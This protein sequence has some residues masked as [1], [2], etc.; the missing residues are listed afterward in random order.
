MIAKDENGREVEYYCHDRFIFPARLDDDD[1]DPS[2][3]FAKR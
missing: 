3:L 1:F 2:K